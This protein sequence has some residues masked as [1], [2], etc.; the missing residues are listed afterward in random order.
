MLSESKIMLH[1]M[2]E[3]SPISLGLLAEDLKKRGFRRMNYNTKLRLG[4][5][6]VVQ[7][8][9][10]KKFLEIFFS[11]IFGQSQAR[12]LRKKMVE[13]SY[14]TIAN[15]ERQRAFQVSLWTQSSHR[16]LQI[17]VQK[18]TIEIIQYLKIKAKISRF[19]ST[20]CGSFWQHLP[21][22]SLTQSVVLSKSQ[23][24][25][26]YRLSEFRSGTFEQ[27][28]DLSYTHVD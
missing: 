16:Y 22:T 13:S 17:N 21:T 2:D 14:S 9:Q 10:S 18:F 26:V 19:G 7:F 15:A 8:L 25:Q 5:S 11:I 20:K 12:I 3:L 4:R 6:L 23:L 1:L 27:P 28:R 24:A